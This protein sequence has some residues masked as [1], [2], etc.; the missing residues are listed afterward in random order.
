MGTLQWGPH[1]VFFQFLHLQYLYIEKLHDATLAPSGIFV[2]MQINAAIE[3]IIEFL[4]KC[5]KC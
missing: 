5:L 3:K 2:K 4:L 1:N